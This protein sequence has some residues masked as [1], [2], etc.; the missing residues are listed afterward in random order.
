MTAMQVYEELLGMYGKPRWWSDD[1][2]TVMFQAVLVQNT[3]WTNVEKVTA[4]I[5]DRLDPKHIVKIST[6]QIEDMI[7][8]CGSF[9]R[10]AQTIKDLA[11]WFGQYGFLS[12]TTKDKDTKEL[13]RELLAIKCIGEETADAILVY[14][15]HRPVF[16]VDAYTRRLLGRLGYSFEDDDSIRQF[17]EDD[18]PKDYKVY[19]YLHWLILDH[20]IQRCKK[21]P[22]C[23]GCVFDGCKDRTL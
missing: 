20:G 14:A 22:K 4:G 23:E 13:R 1:P 11:V 21:R 16:I 2:F 9:K 10:K 3:S 7:R 15:L 18:L 8:K 12:V 19:G 5:G 17:F 6:A